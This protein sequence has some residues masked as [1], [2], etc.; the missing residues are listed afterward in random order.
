MY[1]NFGKRKNSNQLLLSIKAINDSE[2]KINVLYLE[3][4]Q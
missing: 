4:I 3:T 1:L 2:I